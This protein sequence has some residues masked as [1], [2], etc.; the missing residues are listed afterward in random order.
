MSGH[1][2]AGIIILGIAAFLFVMGIKG[3]QH[4]LFPQ[5]FGTPS[6]NQG[7][8]GTVAPG[9][10]IPTNVPDKQGNCTN[11]SINVGGYC[12]KLGPPWI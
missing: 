2:G 6:A 10:N 7:S 1:V 4:Q 9:T 8:Q 11:G 3:T 5:I 12:V